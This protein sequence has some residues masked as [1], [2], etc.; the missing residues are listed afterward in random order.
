[1]N[2]F[3]KMAIKTKGDKQTIY[4]VTTYADKG[5]HKKAAPG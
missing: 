3:I 1:M 5:R 4:E 2:R